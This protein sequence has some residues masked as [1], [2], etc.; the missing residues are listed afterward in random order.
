M[1]F[2][3]VEHW[4]SAFGVWRLAFTARRFLIV[5]PSHQLT[6]SP[7]YRFTA[8]PLHRFTASP[9]HRLTD[10]LQLTPV[11]DNFPGLA[12][13]DELECFL[14]PLVG[15]SM[16]NHWQDIQAGLKHCGHLV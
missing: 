1:S 5:L 10:H 9:F 3:S 14:V 6:V 15:K 11:Q 13:L 7:L 12:A 2:E 8:L 16:G 4:R